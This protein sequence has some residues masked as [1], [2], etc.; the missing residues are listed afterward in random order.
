MHE[1]YY[2]ASVRELEEE[3]NIKKEDYNI[4]I[5]YKTIIESFIGENNVKYENM[6]YIGICN[7][8]KNIK[9]DKNNKDQ[10]MEIKDVKLLT[11]EECINSIRDYNTSKKDVIIK[12]YDFIENYKNDLIL[13]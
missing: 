12:I 3:T 2:E 5:N 9:V 6:Y 11:K 4:I 1:T 13:K 8:T 7:D 10:I